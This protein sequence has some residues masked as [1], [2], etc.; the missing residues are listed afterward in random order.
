MD[1]L[2]NRQRIMPTCVPHA[3]K[4]TLLALG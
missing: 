4:S 3:E 2:R 1:V